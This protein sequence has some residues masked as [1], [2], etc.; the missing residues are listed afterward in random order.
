MCE[1]A[2]AASATETTH[3][4]G[5]FSYLCDDEGGARWAGGRAVQRATR[6]Y[7]RLRIAEHA[8]VGQNAGGVHFEVGS[9]HFDLHVHLQQS[10]WATT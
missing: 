9:A 3:N 8:K 10:C 5:V 7:D 1:E 4:L 6:I 2:H